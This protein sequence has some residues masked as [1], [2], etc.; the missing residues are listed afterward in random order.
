VSAVG[1]T[2]PVDW[3]GSLMAPSCLLADKP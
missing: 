3:C 1:N 2:T